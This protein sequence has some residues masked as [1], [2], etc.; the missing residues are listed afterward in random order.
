ME[1]V[2]KNNKI[3][4][5]FLSSKLKD[6]L[7]G[8]FKRKQNVYLLENEQEELSKRYPSSFEA[9][10][11][12]ITH[13]LYYPDYVLYAKKEKSLFLI[14]DYQRD[15]KFQKVVLRVANKGE[16]DIAELTS[17]SPTLLEHINSLGTL[18]RLN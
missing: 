18:T 10:V 1:V 8:D 15:G 16:W 6:V 4:V 9:K 12:E 13:L 3:T 7:G 5:G 14:R 17:L 2:M 11:E